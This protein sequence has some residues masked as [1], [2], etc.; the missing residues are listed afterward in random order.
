MDMHLPNAHDER[1]L[2]ARSL[3]RALNGFRCFMVN[4]T[5]TILH[6]WVTSAWHPILD[7][8]R[9]RAGTPGSTISRGVSPSNTHNDD[10]FDTSSNRNANKKASKR[11]ADDASSKAGG[12]STTKRKRKEQASGKASR[13]ASVFS[14]RQGSVK[15]KATGGRSYAGS[16]VDGDDGGS[17]RGFPEDNRDEEEDE[18]DEDD[19]EEE[20]VGADVDEWNLKTPITPEQEAIANRYQETRVQLER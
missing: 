8:N 16:F 12:S 19:E 15:G 9:S 17:S 4:E 1:R 14:G 7:M 2:L 6:A 18:E 11:K 10:I 5:L 20:V 3:S 13:P